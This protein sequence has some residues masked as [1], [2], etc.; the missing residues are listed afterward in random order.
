MTRVASSLARF[1]KTTAQLFR[2]RIPLPVVLLLLVILLSP[3]LLRYLNRGTLSPQL[4]DTS[5]SKTLGITQ[6][7]R[8]VK[9][10]LAQM[11]NE[12]IGHNETALFE[13]TNFDLEI[14]FMVQA[15]AEQQGGVQY[16]VVTADSRIQNGMEKIQKLTLH[17]K[18]VNDTSQTDP[19]HSF[20]AHMDTNS[21]NVKSIDKP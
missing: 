16:H 10:E 4:P 11:E 3:Y 6:L 5:G 20:P 7:V 8:D 2:R 9:Q 21:L 1:T 12:R 15:S 14:S 13:V 17:M 18:T 19:I